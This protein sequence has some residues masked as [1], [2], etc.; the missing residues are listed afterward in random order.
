MKVSSEQIS[1]DRFNHCCEPVDS[2][3]TVSCLGSKLDAENF[4]LSIINLCFI[5]LQN[6]M[7][8]IIILPFENFVE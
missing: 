7:W 6:F 3:Q 2:N 1:F 4:S 5:E 8:Y